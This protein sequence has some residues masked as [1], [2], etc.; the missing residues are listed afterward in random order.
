MSKSLILSVS[1]GR[2]MPMSVFYTDFFEKN[3]IKY[4]IIRINRYEKHNENLVTE[5]ENGKIYEYNGLV[6]MGSPFYKKLHLF[7][8]FRKYAIDIINREKYNYIVIWNENTAGVFCS[9]LSRKY[10]GRY[11]VN[12][13]DFYR[14]LFY[15]KLPVH[16]AN[17]NSD[18]ITEPTP[19]LATGFPDKTFLVYNRDTRL[20]KNY[21][22]HRFHGPERPIRITHLGFYSKAELDA[23]Q[24]VGVLG[25]DER[26]ELYF[27][28]QGFES[29]FADYVKDKGYKNVITGGAFPYKDTIKYFEN[30]DIINAYYNHEQHLELAFGIKDSYTPL[31]FIPGLTASITHWARVS[32]EYGGLAFLIDESKIDNLADDLYNWY[33]ALDYDEFVKNCLEFNA[34]V[35]ETQRAI[36]ERLLKKL[37]Q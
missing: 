25:N 24:L 17:K 31:L 10:Q 27:Y 35:L 18:F 22:P 15:A 5:T 9:F 21:T 23:R 20:I 14:D 6:P 36:E 19:G 34:K 32:K 37:K 13:R 1:D 28:G 4:D 12:V 7:L 2:H 29:E 30:T 33:M 26:F 8:N 16:I 11:C 3:N